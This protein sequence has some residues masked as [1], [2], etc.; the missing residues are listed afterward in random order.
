MKSFKTF[1]S[2]QEQKPFKFYSPADP[3][4]G[5]PAQIMGKNL[6]DPKNSP[7]AF[8]SQRG[9]VQQGTNQGLLSTSKIKAQPGLDFINKNKGSIAGAAASIG[10]A[11]LAG[12]LLGK[13]GNLFGGGRQQAQQ[14]SGLDPTSVEGRRYAAGQRVTGSMEKGTTAPKVVGVPQDRDNRIKVPRTSFTEPTGV[15]NA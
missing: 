15:K 6:T 5:K 9:V 11:A 2:E 10:V 4:T 12:P 1:L 13:I 14:P 8:Y 3:D 7:E